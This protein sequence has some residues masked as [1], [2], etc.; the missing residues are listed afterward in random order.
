MKLELIQGKVKAAM[1][2]AS[3]RDLWQVPLDQLHVIDGFNVRTDGIDHKEHLR[4]IVDSILANGFYQSKPLS[5]YVALKNNKQIIY[6]TDGHCRFEAA[7]EAI[8]R[9]AEITA[10]PVVVSPKGTSLED[11][12]VGLVINNSG[13]PLSQYEIGLVCKRL[14]GFGWE[15]KQ[16]A[17]RLCMTTQRVNDL[18]GFVPAPAS[19]RKLVASGTVSATQAIDT[20]KKH[21][22][23]AA[24]RLEVGAQKAKASGKKKATRKHIEDKP[25]YRGVVVALL[26]W[27]KTASGTRD[28]GLKEI[29]KMAK[30]TQ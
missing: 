29:I 3:S 7:Q 14:A 4:G 8:K 26:E 11:L 15:E 9:G 22:A 17:T 24:E 10:L 13:K 18:L 25:T 12:T 6:I 16:I 1:A 21:G 30:A 20:I 27:E 23:D 2:Q 19:V 28:N 5:G